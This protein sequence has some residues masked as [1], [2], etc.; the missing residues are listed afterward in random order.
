MK[1]ILVDARVGWTSGI[2]RYSA[3]AV[4]RVARAMPNIRFDILVTPLDASRARAASK[5]VPNL[6]IREIDLPAFDR[7]EQWRLPALARGYDLTWFVNYWVPLAFRSPFIAVVHDMLHLEPDLFPA[8]RLKRAL[9]RQTFRHLRRH[10][11]GLS[12]D[13]RFTQ[14]EFTRLIGA[15]RLAR[16]CGIGID[17]DGWP[18]FDPAHPPAKEH[19]LLVVAAAKAHKNF[20][21]AIEA[22]LQ[23]HIP[24]HWTLTI[25]TPDSMLRSSIDVAAMAKS[26]TRIDI[27]TGLSNEELRDLY[28]KS[29]IVLMP[30]LYE[31]FGLPLLEG[32]QS[33][34]Q[35]IS[36]TAASLVEVGQGA[37]ISFV[38]PRD[39]EG[40]VEAIEAECSRFDR[41]TVRIEERTA[42]MRRALLHTWDRVTQSTL[43][44]IDAATRTQSK[45]QQAEQ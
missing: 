27:R 35:A 5:G 7:A 43:E 25:V 39:L 11:A 17:H 3:N 18:L 21:I 6:H 1:S 24:A 9:S 44:L 31:G 28:A 15:P 41:G 26:D 12:F 34:S 4:P 37:Q 42:N 33:G 40:W 22:F 19:R 30:S 2:G 10:A 20:R 23:A 14:R 8:S 29:A 36:S 45:R 32:L 13:S 38:N 16:V